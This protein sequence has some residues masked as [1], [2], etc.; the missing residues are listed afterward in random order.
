MHSDNVPIIF[1][2]APFLTNQ[3]QEA[4]R[5]HDLFVSITPESEFHFGHG[6]AT[7]R[8]IFDQASLGLDTNWTFSGD[9]LSQARLWLQTVRQTNFHKTLDKELLPRETPFTVEQAFLMATRQGGLSLKRRDIGVLQVGAK[10]D[11]VVFNGDSPNMLGWH[12]PV[13][14]VILHANPGD[15]EHVLVDGE[16]RK[17][18]FELVNLKTDW[19]TVKERFLKSASRIQPLAAKPPPMADKVFGTGELGDVEVASTIGS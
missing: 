11:I 12:D 1:S 8:L 3:E 19:S 5:K 10:A 15:V 16:F 13:A 2:H 6:Q 14:A 17:R 9:M 7:G 4:L 18:D